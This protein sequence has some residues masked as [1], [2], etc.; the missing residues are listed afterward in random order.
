MFNLE[1]SIADWRRQMLAAGIQ[2]P[3]PLEELEAHLREEIE[4]RMK[5]GLS[6]AEAFTTAVQKIGQRH[7]LQN[8]FNKV[9]VDH[10]VKRVI[11]LIARTTMSIIGWLTA[12]ITLL[13]GL[14]CLDFHW[15][16][17]SLHPKWDLGTIT[18]VV[19]I[20]AA[21]TGIWFL[22]KLSRDKAS[23]VVSLLACLVLVGLA[24]V[25]FYYDGQPTKSNG[26][27][28]PY[29]QPPDPFGIEAA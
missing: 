17:L 25:Y 6:E 10:K 22:A 7:V 9:E 3:V 1:T 27:F 13:Y 16:F 8:E 29:F 21:E 11:M 20:F 4:R 26:I 5:T 24:V 2:T 18:D 14:L 19:L 23:R 15:N 28:G 12:G